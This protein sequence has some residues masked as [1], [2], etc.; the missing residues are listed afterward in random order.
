M[1][2][3][4]PQKCKVTKKTLWKGEK[5]FPQVWHRRLMYSMNLWSFAASSL[6]VIPRRR[7]P[8]SVAVVHGDGLP[9]PTA[10]DCHQ[11]LIRPIE[12]PSAGYGSV[13][14]RG[15]G[16]GYLSA[17]SG[18]S[19]GTVEDLSLSLP[20]LPCLALPT[21]SAQPVCSP[22]Q[23][24]SLGIPT[25]PSFRFSL[26]WGPGAS[27]PGAY[28]DRTGSKDCTAVTPQGRQNRGL[29]VDAQLLCVCE[30]RMPQVIGATKEGFILW[31][32]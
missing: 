15:S 13:A 25:L 2:I 23:W 26:Q 32:V 8:W 22:S 28:W 3:N 1:P 18:T 19:A 5:I 9:L 4:V 11:W 16:L 31:Y 12:D 17:A 7:C 14:R 21:V 6:A 20:G 10:C 27:R 30:I 29:G 24:G